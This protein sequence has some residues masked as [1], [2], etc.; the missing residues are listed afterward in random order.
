MRA[1]GAEGRDQLAIGPRSLRTERG[2]GR[3]RSATGTIVR[4]RKA[5]EGERRDGLPVTQ[6]R[7]ELLRVLG[8]HDVVLVSGETG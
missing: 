5:L 8:V 1:I 2:P 6:I 3:Q 7:N 4:G